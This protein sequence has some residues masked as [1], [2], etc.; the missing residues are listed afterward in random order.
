MAEYC[1]DAFARRKNRA[2]NKKTGDVLSYLGFVRANARLLAFGATAAFASCFG[3]TFFVSLF[4]PALQAELGLSSG[5]LGLLYSGAT[6]CSALSLIWLGRKIDHWDLRLYTLLA[7]LLMILGTGLMSL[8]G[9]T[10]VI[11]VAFYLLRI[12]GQGLLS[13]ISLTSMARYFDQSRG[14][15]IGL[16]SLGF[17]AGEALLPICA[18]SL[19]AAI[20]WRQSWQLIALIVAL[21][22]VPALL[23]CLKGHAA[24]HAAFTAVQATAQGTARGAHRPA[25]GLLISDRRFLLCLPTC[26]ASPFIITGLFF[27]QATIAAAKGWSLD[28]LALCF[29]AFAVTQA[30]TT[31][32]SGHLVDRFGAI[33]LVPVYLLPMAAALIVLSF[34]RT[35]LAALI[36][37]I[38]I[39]VTS[40]FDTTIGTSVWAELF[41]VQRL[42]SIR[43]TVSALSVF[44][45]AL[46]P[47]FFGEL[48]DRAVTADAIALGCMAYC[49]ACALLSLRL[50]RT[51]LPQAA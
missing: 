17:P 19:I 28:W 21:L 33:R 41:G 44:A 12:S 48:I 8:A 31:F 18:V 47:V 36:Y 9:S 37:M 35:P 26:M 32:Q 51:A 16:A 15:A 24:R 2:S 4:N 46:S 10:A 30:L 50:R 1:P 34:W 38:G 5:R 45:S 20:G 27:H 42:G 23:W 22:M 25:P 40:G 7:C 6:L 49:L 11:A 39:G 43:A 13:H 3:Q 29:V 14:R